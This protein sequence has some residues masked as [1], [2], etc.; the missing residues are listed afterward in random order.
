MARR[1]ENNF[2]KILFGKEAEAKGKRRAPLRKTD[3]FEIVAAVIWR[4]SR[5]NSENSSVV[6]IVMADYDSD[7]NFIVIRIL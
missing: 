5:K 6:S 3:G 2:Q 7:E 1:Y 4:R